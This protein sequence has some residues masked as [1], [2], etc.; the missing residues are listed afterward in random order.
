MVL[1]QLTVNGTD[2]L[3]KYMVT[4]HVMVYLSW[5]NSYNQVNVYNSLLCYELISNPI[6]K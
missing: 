4:D 3:S 1:E 6:V 2:T 5:K